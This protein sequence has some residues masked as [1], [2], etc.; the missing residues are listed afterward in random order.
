MHKKSHII[1]PLPRVRCVIFAVVVRYLTA[2]DTNAY[3]NNCDVAVL[4]LE[5]P[6]LLGIS[7]RNERIFITVCSHFFSRGFEARTRR[8]G[9]TELSV[10]H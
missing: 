2:L 9:E 1:G 7:R 5:N 10:Q 6:S 4:S 8:R 3:A